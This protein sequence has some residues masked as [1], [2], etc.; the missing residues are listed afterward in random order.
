MKCLTKRGGK[1]A[2]ERICSWKPRRN[3]RRG[4]SLPVWSLCL[5]DFPQ[6]PVRGRMLGSDCW[7]SCKRSAMYPWEESV[8]L[9]ASLILLCLA[10]VYKTI[11][12]HSSFFVSCSL[13]LISR[14]RGR[15]RLSIWQLRLMSR[16]ASS[17]GLKSSVNY[18]EGWQS[19]EAELIA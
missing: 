10:Q 13:A 12:G 5:T 4:F 17:T 2:T 6:S 18:Q 8:P 1:A 16:T 19:E 15:N 7:Q 3:F 14:A 11:T 9:D